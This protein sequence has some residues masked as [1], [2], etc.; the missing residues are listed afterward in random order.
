MRFD[1]LIKGGEILDPGTGYFGPGDVAVQRDRV[2]AVERQIPA[3]SAFRTIDASGL[4]VTPG[5]VDMHTHVWHGAGYYGIDADPI[6]AASGVTSWVD[7]GSAGAFTLEGLR[8][9]IIEPSKVRIAAF[10][11]QHPLHWPRRMGLRVDQQRAGRRRAIRNGSKPPSRHTVWCEGADGSDDSGFEWRRAGAAR[12][13][14]C[15][16]L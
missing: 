8:R 14:G 6:G 9:Y 13:S 15:R 12:H 10:L 2:A 1:L 3:E 11:S 16:T 5:L 4:L 7:A